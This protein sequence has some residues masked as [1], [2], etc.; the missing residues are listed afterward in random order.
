MNLSKNWENVEELSFHVHNKEIIRY[1][2]LTKLY[3]KLFTDIMV[4]TYTK[5]QATDGKW[6]FLRKVK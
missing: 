2:K 4:Y 3:Q 5:I 6:L 1:L